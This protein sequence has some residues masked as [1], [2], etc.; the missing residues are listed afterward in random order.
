MQK[1]PI[2]PCIKTCIKWENTGGI[3]KIGDPNIAP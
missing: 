3:P 2:L 1:Y